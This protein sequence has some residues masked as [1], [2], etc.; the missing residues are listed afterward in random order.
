MGADEFTAG[1]IFW[2]VVL[3][4]VLAYALLTLLINGLYSTTVL[5]LFPQ[6]RKLTLP[7]EKLDAWKQLEKIR[8]EQQQLNNKNEQDKKNL[9]IKYTQGKFAT[10]CSNEELEL[11]CQYVISYAQKRPLKNIKPITINGLSNLDLYH[12]G[13]NIWKHFKVGKQEEV[14]IFLKSVFATQLK[15]VEVDTIKSHLKDDELK[16][17]IKIQKELTEY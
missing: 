3:L 5:W 9:G 6:K 14:S 17:I 12:F 10:Y 11:L 7:N 4:G 8:E 1:I 2:I 15:D 13:W 16:G